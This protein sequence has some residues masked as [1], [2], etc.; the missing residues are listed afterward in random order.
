MIKPYRDIKIPICIEERDIECTWTG[1]CRET[2]KNKK[3]R[4]RTISVDGIIHNIQ[5][6]PVKEN[7]HFCIHM[8]NK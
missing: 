5:E 2:C 1:W 3:I 7:E 4:R 6:Y 8:L